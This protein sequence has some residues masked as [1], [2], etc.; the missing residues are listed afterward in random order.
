MKEYGLTETQY[1][2]YKSVKRSFKNESRKYG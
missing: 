1:E 2:F